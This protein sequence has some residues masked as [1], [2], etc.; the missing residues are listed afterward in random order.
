MWEYRGARGAIMN[1]AQLD[2][3]REQLQRRHSTLGSGSPVE[4]E[5]RWLS[6]NPVSMESGEDQSFQSIA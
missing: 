2:R 1:A 3:L 4:T 5:A 6:R